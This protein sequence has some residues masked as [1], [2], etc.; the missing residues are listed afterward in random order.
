MATKS[1]GTLK[2]SLVLDSAGFVGGFASSQRAAKSF[3]D[4]MATKVGS[5]IT[6]TA[7]KFLAAQKIVN[8]TGKA[9]RGATNSYERL[10]KAGS[11]QASAA[12]K[13]ITELGKS[14]QQGVDK[15]L[16]KIAPNVAVFGSTVAS[17]ITKAVSAMERWD[18]VTGV[19]SGSMRNLAISAVLAARAVTA[20]AELAAAT[21]ES[22]KA[23]ADMSK[24]GEGMLNLPPGS[25]E[26]MAAFEANA[27]AMK[28]FDAA[29]RAEKEAVQSVKDL[30]S[31][32]A[33]NQIVEDISRAAARSPSGSSF[34]P[35]LS[36]P[37][38]P[39]ER[40][41]VETQKFVLS[42]MGHDPSKSAVEKNT[43][44]TVTA[45][46]RIERKLDPDKTATAVRQAS[47]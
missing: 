25:K 42:L 14:V 37:G 46:E 41:T 23:M 4:S 38:N 45:L 15:F 5:T 31:G 32:V 40:G 35:K 26:Q 21:A 12:S 22:R 18:K 16:L 3:G 47:L 43:A 28:D 19:L 20:T 7:F 33:I 13:A 6:R 9:L 39:L 30:F 34:V 2:A 24:A 44:A 11:D 10:A 29:R 36:A 27:K 17:E 8:L 1:I